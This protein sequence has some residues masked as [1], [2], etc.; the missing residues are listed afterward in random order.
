MVNRVILDFPQVKTWDA[1]RPLC[2]EKY[3]NV[4]QGGMPLYSDNVHLNQIGSNLLAK[5][6]ARQMKVWEGQ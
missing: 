4:M 1:T 3:C 5:D 6:F 2:N